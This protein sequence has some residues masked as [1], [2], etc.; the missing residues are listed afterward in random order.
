MIEAAG[1][2]VPV[3][4]TTGCDA[5][6]ELANHTRLVRATDGSTDA[7]AAA[8]EEV[9]ATF[10]ADPVSCARELVEAVDQV[11]GA[12]RVVERALGMLDQAGARH[13]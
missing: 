7:M 13:G 10:R 11:C 8:I 5:A 9:L 4:A 1:R 3:V 6:T 12:D 2:G